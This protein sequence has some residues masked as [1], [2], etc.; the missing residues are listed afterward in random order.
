MNRLFKFCF[1]YKNAFNH[2]YTRRPLS[3]ET[4]C[5]NFNVRRGLHDKQR[6]IRSTLNYMVALG[7]MTVGLSYAA[8]PLYRI[9]CQVSFLTLIFFFDVQNFLVV[10]SII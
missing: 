5:I 4:I 10:Y 8:V 1:G 6:K 9:F 7:V 3:P 2:Q